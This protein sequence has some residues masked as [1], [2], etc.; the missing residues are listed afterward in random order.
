M[1]GVA[2]N[3]RK[4]AQLDLWVAVANVT[5]M[6]LEDFLNLDEFWQQAVFESVNHFVKEQ[7]KEQQKSLNSMTER[8]EQL[9]PYSSPMAAVP[10]PQFSM[11]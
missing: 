5:H 4:K 6:T 1:Q 7:N 11:P 3:I 2:Q 9:R 8:I 10:K